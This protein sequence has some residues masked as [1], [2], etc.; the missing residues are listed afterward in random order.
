MSLIKFQQD[1]TGGNGSD[2]HILPTKSEL[3]ARVFFIWQKSIAA[4][5][6]ALIVRFFF[7]FVYSENQMFDF[8]V[9]YRP[10]RMHIFKTPGFLEVR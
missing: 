3:K 6:I 8:S 7:P 9:G 5:R 10:K 2:H 1:M 4:P